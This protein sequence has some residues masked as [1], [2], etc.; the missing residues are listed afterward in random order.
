MNSSANACGKIILSGEYSVIFGYPGIALPSPLKM[1]VIFEEHESDLTIDWTGI[2][3][4]QEWKEYLRKI[5]DEIEKDIG[6]I[7]GSLLNEHN[8]PLG[9]GMGSSTSLVIALGRLFFD[10]DQDKIMQ[11][12]E[13]MNPGSSG[14]DFAVIW[15]EFPL[16][17]Q[18]ETTPQEVELENPLQHSF[19]IDT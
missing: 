5:L 8:L 4:T 12:E 17:F 15:N 13:V 9:K 14:I 6:K 16:L 10:E 11:L 7:S 3:P 19:F 18:R 1:K 2:K